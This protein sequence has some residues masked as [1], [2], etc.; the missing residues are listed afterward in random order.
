MLMILLVFLLMTVSFTIFSI[1]LQLQSI[2]RIVFQT[3]KGIVERC[4]PMK[5]EEDYIP[6]F[7]KELLISKLTSYYEE[8]LD[9]YT[10]NVNVDFYFYNVN[11][12]SYCLN[13]EC[14]GVKVT[15]NSTV[16]FSFVYH[17]TVYFEIREGNVYG[18]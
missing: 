16:S 12:G 8:V 9:R 14:D 4:I 6:H 1:G 11:D 15:I 10:K 2:N 3:P 17:R 18:S 13:D 7:D 5:Y